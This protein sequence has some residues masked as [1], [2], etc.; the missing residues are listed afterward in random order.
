[1]NRRIQQALPLLILI[2]LAGM[3]I[4]LERT[5]RI[6]DK[7][8]SGS[9]RH[10]PDVI[11]DNFTLYRYDETGAIQHTLTA[12]QMRHYPDDDSAEL[13]HPTLRYEGKLAPT[14]IS[15]ERALLTKDGKEAILRDNVRV[16]REASPGRAEMTLATSLLYV[17]PEE[18]IART[19]QPVRMTQGKS[20]ATGVGM[21]A[22]RIKEN[23]VLESRVK[24]T[25]ERARRP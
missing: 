13:D 19:D 8:S 10:D 25:I 15:S 14:H 18:E 2:A 12:R 20:V 6:E 5:T 17:Y 11:I 24:A 4:W 3:T 21:V 22:D 23:Y 9:L 16:L 7:P 1:M